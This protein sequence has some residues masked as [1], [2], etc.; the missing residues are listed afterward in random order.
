MT[1]ICYT[2]S[3]GRQSHRIAW[4][5]RGVYPRT[6]AGFYSALRHEAGMLDSGFAIRIIK[7][8]DD[9]SRKVWLVQQCNP[10]KCCL[11]EHT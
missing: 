11:P 9:D 6:E 10:W 1:C 8:R 4:V 3:N 2:M 7:G 5:T